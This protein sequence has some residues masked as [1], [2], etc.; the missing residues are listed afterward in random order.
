MLDLDY[1]LEQDRRDPL[2]PFR[3]EFVIDDP[4]TIYLDGNSLGRLPK[5]TIA[6]LQE[7]VEQQWGKRMVRGWG[8]GWMD[9]PQRIGAKIA[10]LIGA[11]SDEVLVADS[12]STNF[13]KLVC[14][15]LDARS[16]RHQ[17]V[18]EIVNFPTDAYILQGI[19]RARGDHYHITYVD[20]QD[21]ITISTDAI[22]DALNAK[23]CALVT[24]THT[25]FK[26]GYVYDMRAIT[27]A[28]H[29]AGALVLWDLSHS[30]GSI[31]VHLNDC[32]ADFAV[33][34]T[35]KYLNGGPGAPAFL[36]VRRDLQAQ[37]MN[38][39]QGWFGQREPIC[40]GLELYSGSRADPLSRWHAV[41][42]IAPRSRRRSRL[43]AGSRYDAAARKIG[44]PNRVSHR[45][46]GCVA[47]SARCHAQFAAQ[48]ELSRF[49]HF[50]RTP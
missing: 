29:R 50:T 17:I 14:A 16:G 39:I 20:S 19:V 9:A 28:A 7:A 38:P 40:N 41:H 18:T 35:Y 21:G 15:A 22:V 42:P 13:Y 49:A 2:A 36:Y 45:A 33:G 11:Q 46:V 8:E 26:S 27:D 37:A 1:A 47:A 32:N 6:R 24:L 5:R 34:C 44:C 30:V 48:R 43:A 23:D 3:A 25:A 12:T 4:D 31:P 10:Q